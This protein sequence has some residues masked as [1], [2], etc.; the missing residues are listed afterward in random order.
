MH[1][2]VTLTN[3]LKYRLYESIEVD[4]NILR[5]YV[6]NYS[7]E[8]IPF[9]IAI[10]LENKKLLAQATGQKALPLDATSIT[11]FKFEPAGI[12]IEFDV[13]KKQMVLKQSGQEFTFKKD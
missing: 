4:E 3:L 10:I 9:Q 5:T 7:S 8:Q 6:G 1:K 13:E 11:A 2:A 12:V